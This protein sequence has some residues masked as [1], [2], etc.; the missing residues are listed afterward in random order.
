MYRRPAVTVIQEF[1]GL[2]PALA[3]FNLPCV[4]VG[5]AYQ[6]VTAAAAGNYTGIQTDY[7][8]PGLIPGA[9]VDLEE[10]ALDEQFPATKTL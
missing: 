4:C 8:Y 5:P 2:V 10:L 9:Q 1:A 3:A 7:A 6:L